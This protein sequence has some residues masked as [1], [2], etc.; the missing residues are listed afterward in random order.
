MK[1]IPPVCPEPDSGVKYWRSQEQLADSPDFQAWAEKEFPAGASELQDGATRRDFM[2]LMSASFALA[3]AGMLGTGCRRPVENIYPFS[4]LPEGYIHGVAQHFATAMPNRG[5]AIPLVVKSHEGRPTKVEGNSLLPG[6]NGGTDTFAQASILGLYDA[7][8]AQLFRNKSNTVPREVALDALAKL[9]QQSAANQGEGVCFLLDA[10]NSPS[11]ERLQAMVSQKLPKARWFTHEPVDFSVHQRAASLVA[12]ADVAP[13]F[14]LGA[15]NVIL[16]LDCDFIGTEEDRTQHI[17]AFAKGRKVAKAG[18]RMNRLYAVEALMTQTGMNADHRLRVA[19]STV[20]AVAAHVAAAVAPGLQALAAKFPLPA[21]VKPEWIKE[22]AAD[23][24]KH[25]G[26]SLVLA[27]Y[28]QPLAVHLMALALNNALNNFGRTVL[29]QPAPAALGTLAELAGLLNA[30]GVNTLAILGGNPAYSAPADLNWAATQRKAKTVVRLGAHEDETS[31]GT[32]WHLPAA[33]YLESWGDAQT[34]DGTL[35]PIQPLIEPLFGGLTEIEVLARLG[36]LDVVKPHDIAR[37]SFMVFATSNV[38]GTLVSRATFEEGWKKFLH[39]GFLAGSAMPVVAG[40][41]QSGAVSQA[42][43]AVPAPAAPSKAQLEVIF[44]RDSRVD[45]GRFSNNG[46]L[47]EFPDPVTKITW[48]NAVLMSR[49]T[50]AELG[51]KN[52]DVVEV[53]LGGRSVKGPVW[54]QPGQADFTLGLALGYG[55]EKGGRIA[56]FNG[57]TVG[58]NA[59]KLRLSKDGDIVVGATV[60]ATGATQKVVTTQDHWSM[61]G[62]PIIREGTKAEFDKDVNFAKRFNLPDPPSTQPM[63]PNPFDE[64]KKKPNVMHQWGMVIDLNSCVGCSACVLACQSENNVPI[65]GKDQMSRGREMH[66]LRI[67]RY[68]AGS[69]EK[70]AHASTLAGTKNVL[71][72]DSQQQFEEWIDEPQVVNQPMLCLHCEAAPCESV[73]PVNATAH[74]EE[75]LNV[76]VYNRCVGTR[77][78][79]NNCPYKVR[80]FNFFDYNKRPLENLYQS[81]L[82][83]VNNGEWGLLSWLKNPDKGTKREDEWD[84]MKLARNPDVSVRMRG[85]M[86]KCTFCVQRIEGAKISQKVKAGASGDVVVPDGTIKTACQQACPAEAISFGNLNDANSDVSKAKQNPRNYSVLEFLATKPRTTYLARVRNPNPKMPDAYTTPLTSQEWEKENGG[87]HDDG[88]HGAK[89]GAAHG[90]KGEKH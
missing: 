84:I 51:V 27:G 2:K 14:Q 57:G 86:E 89:A 29:F 25:P 85:V 68:Y 69:P 75:G 9:A 23:L 41:F 7:D 70:Q 62:R 17:G 3:G 47:Q 42:L 12:G 78:C 80:R 58:F 21:G 39:D 30:G 50:A 76:M 63:Y 56:N 65:V 18:D 67:D 24:A 48:D 28:R 44:T 55:R 35:V 36:G 1:T 26:G 19:S 59:Y 82:F 73:C 5:S 66:W 20:I 34:S 32:D 46:W 54:V 4:R 61:E 87:H 64:L 10:N 40:S 49:K 81:P 77:Y 8:R 6:S 74:D 38:L 22:C 33:H 43:A 45:D 79:S 88:G 15:A 11:R 71:R 72:K 90:K 16:S 31:L 83:S 60:K 52:D 37:D 13:R 53:S